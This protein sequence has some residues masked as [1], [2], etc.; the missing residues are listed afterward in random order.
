MCTRV[1]SNS[2]S[3]F[4]EM[5]ISS[6]RQPPLLGAITKQ[7]SHTSSLSQVKTQGGARLDVAVESAIP[8]AVLLPQT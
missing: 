7:L 2:F 4:T 8:I 3:L 6:L 1:R 5:T